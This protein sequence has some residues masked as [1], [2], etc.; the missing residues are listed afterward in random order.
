MKYKEIKIENYKAIKN[1]TLKLKQ[2]AIPIIGINESGKTSIL[3]GIFC[4]DSTNDS[5]INRIHLRALTKYHKRKTSPSV[6]AI[7]EF[8][9]NKELKSFL[10]NFS[11]D[12]RTKKYRELRRRILK[13]NSITLIRDLKTKEYSIKIDNEKISNKK[14]KD[15]LIYYV[16]NN[17]PYII[18][19]DEVRN[20]IQQ[21]LRIKPSLFKKPY[22]KIQYSNEWL[23]HLIEIF[24]RHGYSLK[25]FVKESINDQNIILNTISSNLNDDIIGEWQKFTGNKLKIEL[26]LSYRKEYRR[27]HIFDL[28]INDNSNALKTIQYNFTDRSSGFQWFLYFMLKL[29]YNFEYNYKTENAIF[30]LD[31]PGSYLHSSAQI[32]LLNVLTKVAKENKIIFST[33]SQFMLNPNYVNISNI[34]IAERDSDGYIQLTNYGEY[35]KINKW[36]GA[37]APLNHALH[38][39]I[40]TTQTIA[41]SSIIITEGITEFYLLKLF[42]KY[43]GHKLS[44]TTIIPG[45]S[46]GNLKDL[47][48]LAISLSK[49]YKVLLDNDDAGRNAFLKYKN[50]FGEDEAKNFIF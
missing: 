37:L 29:K 34:K 4:L 33:H 50:F 22:Y 45:A 46:A 12:Y 11:W 26:K 7:V 44:M 38:L 30:L 10:K 42:D 1:V 40:L 36:Q 48:S 47:I 2:S 27:D 17:T 3:H 31:E 23:G 24:W 20:S 9:N 16:I 25:K 21:E 19:I 13:T 5:R 15:K 14:Q 28:I 35:N 41:N 39:D 18:Y 32:D 6:T 8:V 49:K 43:N